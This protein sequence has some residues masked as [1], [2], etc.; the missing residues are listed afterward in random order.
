MRDSGMFIVQKQRPQVPKPRRKQQV[1]ASRK[2]IGS[3]RPQRGTRGDRENHG[4][5]KHP[6]R[7][8]EIRREIKKKHWERLEEQVRKKREEENRFPLHPKCWRPGKKHD[9]RERKRRQVGT[10]RKVSMV[11]WQRQRLRECNGQ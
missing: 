4:S 8:T 10:S 11:K 6:A 9:S 1:S 5:Q 2:K 3:I 7:I